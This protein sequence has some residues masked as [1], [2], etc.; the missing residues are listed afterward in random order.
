MSAD[1][2]ILTTCPR[3][4]YDACG[5]EVAVRDGA[6][7]H[8]RGDPDHPVSR[9]RLC[10]KCTSAYNG[11]FLDPKARLQ[12]PLI[13]EGPKGR[14]AFRRASWDEA[15][16]LV[17]SRLTE[18]VEDP[19]AGPGTILN[20]HY[21]GTFALLG[22]A[23]GLRFM[24]ALGAREVDPDTICNKSGHVALDYLFGTSEDG[25]DPRSAADADCILVWG[26][27]PSASAPHQHEQWLPEAPGAVIVVDSLRTDTARQA[28]LHLQPFPGSDAALAFSLAHV[29]QR[30]GRLDEDLL[31]DH[32]VGWPELAPVLR[33]CSPTWAEEVTGVPVAAIERAA[34]LYGAGPSLLWIGQGFQRQPHG[35]NAVRAVAQLAA[36]SGNLGRPGTGVLYLNGPENRGLDYDYVATGGLVNRSPDPISHMDLASWL[37]DP[38]RTRAL[39]CWNNNIAASNPDQARL[40]RALIR[41]DLFTVTIELFE[42][43]TTDLSDVVLPAASFLESDDLVA[44]YF[45]LSLSAQVAATAPIGEALANS[46]I[47]RRLAAAMRMPDPALYESDREVLDHLLQGTGLGLSFDELAARGTVWCGTAPRIQF[48]G[49]AFPTPSGHVEL[50]SDRAQAAGLPRVAQPYFDRRPEGDRLRLLT[51]ASRWT[52]NDSFTNEPRLTG[53]AGAATV[54]LHP[55]DAAERGLGEG[56]RARLRSSAGELELP[57]ALSDDVPR[58]VA[59]SP[60]G[61]WPRREQQHA[62][63]NVLNPGLRS[64]MGDS[65]TVHGIEV[66]VTAVD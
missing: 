28:D 65:S 34:E 43:D 11:V 24:R 35:G 18:I 9:G 46:E 31:R 54:T 57:V 21:T 40:R 45:H 20:T 38:V 49:L 29:M 2:T 36:L 3:D 64:D 56:D 19:S 15:L 41:E 59:L 47:F 13:R 62:N 17:A 25:F 60:K 66:S 37:E 33:T 52:L 63:V 16:A 27:N 7:R 39:I 42:T 58:G 14:G 48:A 6:I 23:F 22:Y 32:C 30:D 12:T 55:A 4:C 51:P 8:V 53:R 61:R 44:S 5:I 10:Q 26:A 1:T 50:A